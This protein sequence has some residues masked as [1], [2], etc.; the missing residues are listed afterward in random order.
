MHLIGPTGTSLATHADEMR[1]SDAI[2]IYLAIGS[3]FAV[4]HFLKAG[5][6]HTSSDILRAIPA[7]LFWPAYVIWVTFRVKLTKDDRIVNSSENNSLDATLDKKVDAVTS[8]L[9][10]F[11][12]D[13]FPETTLL[14][15]RDI[16][17]RYIGLTRA[18]RSDRSDRPGPFSKIVPGTAENA[19][20]NSICI[21]RRNRKGL[22][23]HRNR[24][25]VD[26]LGLV[27]EVAD[28]DGSH[29][30]FVNLALELSRIISD[31]E[32]CREIEMMG[33]RG[34]Q[35]MVENPVN[36]VERE[37]WHSQKHKPSAVSRI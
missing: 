33:K 15:Y 31:T 11:F 7:F 16:L 29:S 1:I 34:V 37:V 24:A 26:F 30:A 36:N 5:R 28:I 2:I 9:E 13:S 8:A 10:T 23:A 22:E 21:N 27:S 32:A 6:D 35:T 19:E 14:E 3:P 4:H 18:L 17:D 20:L 12:R 25:R